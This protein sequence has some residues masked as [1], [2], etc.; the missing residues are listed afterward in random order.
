MTE[1]VLIVDDEQSMREILTSWLEDSGYNTLSSSTGTEALKEI[2]QHRPDLIVAD[3]IMPDM[4]GYKLCN[5]ASEISN[6]SIILLTAL[7][8]EKEK[9]QGYQMGADDYIVKP[10]G[11][12][13]FLARV[14]AVL[15][16]RTAPNDPVSTYNG[17]T[18]G[19]L[20]IDLDRHEVFVRGELVEFTPT[21]FKLICYLTERAEKAC[22]LRDIL[23]NVWESPNYPLEIIKWHMSK[24]RTKIEENP[25]K[26]VHLITVRG[27]GYRY[28]LPQ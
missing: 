8:Q 7:G 17:Y 3:V 9:V 18:D 21:E 15:R 20:N 2:Y 11:M 25:S 19:L 4:D 22:N 16:R 10:I 24:L 14:G 6:S 13:E 23:V 5:L 12:S 28:E 26:P 1:T 27:L